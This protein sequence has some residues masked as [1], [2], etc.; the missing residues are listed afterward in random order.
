MEY[1][2]KVK[3]SEVISHYLCVKNIIIITKNN[4]SV[5]QRRLRTYI[6]QIKYHYKRI[7]TTLS[8]VA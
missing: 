2:K 8:T 5:I 4:L 7:L 6:E 1:N 3:N